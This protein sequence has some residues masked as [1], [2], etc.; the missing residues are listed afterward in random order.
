[1]GG[2]GAVCS[3][4]DTLCNF[5]V[6]DKSNTKLKM[7]WKYFQE[8]YEYQKIIVHCAFS[9]FHCFFRVIL[10]LFYRTTQISNVLC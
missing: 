6:Q 3:G 1:M 9:F 8:K 4:A 10:E 7:L 2:V 5:A